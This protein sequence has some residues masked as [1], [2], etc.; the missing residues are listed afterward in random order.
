MF[1]LKRLYLRPRMRGRGLG[2]RLFERRLRAV[3]ALGADKIVTTVAAPLDANLHL[4]RTH[5]FTVQEGKTAGR[6]LGD[7]VCVWQRQEEAGGKEGREPDVKGGDDDKAEAEAEQSL[8]SAA[9]SSSSSSS[10]APSSQKS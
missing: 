10:A 7:C 2:R 5:G 4:H 1:L 9:G 8:T 6:N 3:A